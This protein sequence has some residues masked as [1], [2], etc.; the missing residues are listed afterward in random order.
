MPDQQETEQTNM[1]ALGTRRSALVTEVGRPEELPDLVS[2]AEVDRPTFSTEGTAK[3]RLE[4][5]LSRY[6]G[7]TDVTRWIKEVKEMVV[8]GKW[9]EVVTVKLM[10]SK[11]HGEARSFMDKA[12]TPFETITYDKL[13]SN[14]EIRFKP[15]QSLLSRLIEFRNVR[16]NRGEPI[17][18]FGARVRMLGYEATS[19]T[20]EVATLDPRLLVAFTMGLHDAQLKQAVLMARPANFTEAVTMALDLEAEFGKSLVKSP[21]INVVEEWTGQ[22]QEV[23]AVGGSY[24]RNGRSWYKNG[25][26]HG[27]NENQFAGNRKHASNHNEGT[28]SGST[29]YEK[30]N[31][32]STGKG[33][34]VKCTF[35]KKIGHELSQCRRKLFNE[36][37]CFIRKETGHQQ[38]EYP[39]AIEQQDF[40][41]AP[42]QME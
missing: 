41:M 9:S 30:R 12:I 33:K 25:T 42:L 21:Q 36:G 22:E 38:M 31:G 27:N 16:Q 32:T 2:P 29:H 37:K 19:S 11:L 6:D 35:C 15:R 14:L 4:D 39:E 10:M 7:S 13:I 1:G 26:Q 40:S 5:L 20:A 34:K 18:E 23:N 3:I 17:A 28:A 24:N 8:L